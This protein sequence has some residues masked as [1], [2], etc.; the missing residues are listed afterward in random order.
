M[1]YGRPL[2]TI[3]VFIP[4]SRFKIEHAAQTFSE[5]QYCVHRFEKG[6]YCVLLQ[7]RKGG[8]EAAVISPVYVNHNALS[9]DGGQEY[10]YAIL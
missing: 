8:V 9:A 7:G 6:A 10:E 1:S 3:R 4:Q 2:K 5:D